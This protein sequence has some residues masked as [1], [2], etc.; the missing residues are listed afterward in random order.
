MEPDGSPTLDAG[1][2]RGATGVQVASIFN[3]LGSRVELF[4]AGPRILPTEDEDVSAAVAAAFRDSGIVVRENFG[5]IES[6]EKTPRGVRMVFAKNGARDS[7]E[8]ALAVVTIGWVADTAK[9]NLPA[10][11]VETSSRGCVRVDPYLRTS[12]Q[13]VF[14]A[15]DI[16]GRLMLVPQAI[17]DGFVAGTNAVRG[18]TTTLGDQV[19]P[20]GSFTD[21]E[22]AQVGLTEAQARQAH[23]VVVA[24]VRFDETTRTI[25]DG[26]TAGFCK[27]IADRGTARILGCHV[28]GERAVDI[29]QAVAIAMTGGLRVDELAGI[30]LS[31]PTYAGMIGRAAYRAATQLGRELEWRSQ[32]GEG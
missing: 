18:A 3:A 5:N 30:P 15:G 11:G 13:H 16:T 21:P 26:R 7:A 1:D 28:V 10:A 22:Y 17:N 27:L 8:A 23:D 25:I 14:A 4:Q 9:L 31:F 20:I 24:V 2:R 29:V 19:S 32:E 12:A 6:F